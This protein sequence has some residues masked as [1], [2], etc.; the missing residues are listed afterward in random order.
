LE[1]TAN[2]KKPSSAVENDNDYYSPGLEADDVIISSFT[3]GTSLTKKRESA[4]LTELLSDEDKNKIKE[5]ILKIS[6]PES[7]ERQ[8]L[9][10][11]HK[12]FGAVS[13]VTDVLGKSVEDIEWEEVK[14]LPK[15]VMELENNV[16]RVYF[17]DKKG[18]VEAVEV[19]K[20]GED[21]PR[22]KAEKPN[23]TSGRNL[24]AIPS[25]ED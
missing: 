5:K 7:L 15:G 1:R 16:F 13:K 25:S 22:D 12:L 3:R 9:I 11:G 8:N 10:L 20:K 14:K 6:V 18:I 4:E 21:L 2:E 19:L 17:D 24:P 23:S